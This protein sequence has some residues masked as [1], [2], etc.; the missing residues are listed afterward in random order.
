MNMYLQTM[1]MIKM[2]KRMKALQ[3]K[4]WPFLQWGARGVNLSGL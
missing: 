3:L 4:N 2:M 1:T